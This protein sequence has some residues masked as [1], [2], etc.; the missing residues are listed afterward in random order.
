MNSYGW[1]DDTFLIRLGKILSCFL[2]AIPVMNDCDSNDFKP[3]DFLQRV[4]NCMKTV[5]GKKFRKHGAAD[6]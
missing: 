4:T 2:F 1:L 6:E 3:I 5:Y